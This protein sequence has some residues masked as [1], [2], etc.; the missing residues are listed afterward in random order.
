M[1]LFHAAKQ[2]ASRPDD[3]R[4]SSLAEMTAVCHGHR[5]SAR[6]ARVASDGI[7]ILAEDGELIANGKSGVK[8]RLTNFAMGQL[9][10]RAHAPASYLQR[11]PAEMAAE[12]L[13]HG[14]QSSA[15]TETSLLFHQN[16]S[17]VLRAAT[18]ESYTRIWNADVLDRLSDL[19]GEWKAPP[20]RPAFAGQK[21]TRKATE[22]DVLRYAAHKSLG[23]KVGDDIAPSGLYASDRDMFVFLVDDT[24]QIEVNGAMLTRGFFLWNSEVGDKSLGIQTFMLDSVCGNHIVWGAQDV[25]EM[26]IRHT[27]NADSQWHRTV[28]VELRKYAESSALG[29]IQKIEKAQRTLIAGSKDDVLD[30]L[31][32]RKSLGLSKANIEGAYSIAERTPRYGDPKSAWGIANGLTELS[33][34]QPHTETRVKLDRAAGQI[35]E[36]AF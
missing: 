14:L 17:L 4:F 15:V 36:I 28:N 31:F 3:E 9:C 32:G 7:R 30:I 27:G 19:G 13:N 16:G 1:E 10:Q 5:D 33:Q 21:G 22:D 26:R 24:R 8:A 29:D 11:L 18:S 35:L 25:R 6:T 34:M 20:A 12:C 2:W 23:V